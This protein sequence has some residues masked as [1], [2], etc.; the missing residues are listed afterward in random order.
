MTK[1]DDRYGLNSQLERVVK[2]AR[3]CNGA[4][5]LRDADDLIPARP[6]V[7]LVFAW[8]AIVAALVMLLGGCGG[9][10]DTM[11][12]FMGPPALC[13]VDVTACHPQPT[14]GAK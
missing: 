13:P 10:I 14:A 1:P 6:N 7:W 3:E 9:G 4:D 8:L 2:A 5:F 12:E 11:D